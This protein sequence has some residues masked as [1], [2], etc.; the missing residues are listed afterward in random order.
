MTDMLRYQDVF[1]KINIP[2]TELHL[3]LTAKDLLDGIHDR[4]NDQPE[5]HQHLSRI[6]DTSEVS[7]AFWDFENDA[8]ATYDRFA[9]TVM[10][11]GLTL[12]IEHRKFDA[13]R[14]TYRA[15]MRIE[16]GNA[17]V[18]PGEHHNVS[19]SFESQFEDTIANL[20]LYRRVQALRQN[21]SSE[22][23]FASAA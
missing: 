11:R 22:A 19:R 9:I 13:A 1:P 14:T 8:E 10:G 18:Y 23:S 20:G 3:A 2:E 21:D 6:I 7:Q 5:L 15:T 16:N 4:W 17:I 12:A